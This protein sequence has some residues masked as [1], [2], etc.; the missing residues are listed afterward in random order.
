[1]DT[2]MGSDVVGNSVTY[3]THTVH[4]PFDRRS[5]RCRPPQGVEGQ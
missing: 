1:M 2:W 4:H 5:A 3:F